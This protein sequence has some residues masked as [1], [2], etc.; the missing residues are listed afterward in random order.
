VTLERGR[1]HGMLLIL[2]MFAV[3]IGSYAGLV[4]LVLFSEGILRPR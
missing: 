1:P 4:A 3:L 2:L